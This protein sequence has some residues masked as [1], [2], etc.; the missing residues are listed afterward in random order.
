MARAQAAAARADGAAARADGAAARAQRLTPDAFVAAAQWVDRNDGACDI[1][2]LRALQA[3]NP[4][5]ASEIAGQA[6]A[7]LDGLKRQGVDDVT[8]DEAA[9]FALRG[10]QVVH[11]ILTEPTLFQYFRLQV[12]PG[13]L[14]AALEG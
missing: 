7:V 5:A 10:Q 11:A 1:A 3:A 9:H 2:S 8:L 12:Q 4:E 6:R 14:Y 13:A